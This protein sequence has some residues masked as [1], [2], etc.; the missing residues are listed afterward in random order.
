MLA[1]FCFGTGRFLVETAGPE[2]GVAKEAYDDCVRNGHSVVHCR[3]R[4]KNEPRL[5]RAERSEDSGRSG[6]KRGGERS[7]CIIESKGQGDAAQQAIQ[8]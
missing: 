6:G 7:R 1:G 2:P 3:Q 4:V 5:L 8:Q